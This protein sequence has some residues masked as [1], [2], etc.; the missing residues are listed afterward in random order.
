[1]NNKEKKEA[2]TEE[3]IIGSKN[4]TATEFRKFFTETLG[5]DYEKHT[6]VMDVIKNR[7]KKSMKTSPLF[8]FKGKPKQ[9]SKM[10]SLIISTAI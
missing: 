2:L 5:D 9:K 10:S 7:Y 8:M 6:F 4:I 3:T 1:M